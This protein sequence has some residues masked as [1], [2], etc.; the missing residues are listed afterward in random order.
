MRL[1]N[2]TAILTGAGSGLGAYTAKAFA[3]EGAA[4]VVTDIDETLGRQVAQEIEAAGGRAVFAPLDVTDEAAWARVTAAALDSFGKIDILINSAGIVVSKSIEESTL[5]DL[6]KSFALNVEGPFLGIRAVAPAMRRNGGGAIVTIASMSGILGLSR[7]APYSTSKGAV[8]L[9]SK[10]AA[11]HF[12]KKGDNIRVNTVN[13]SYVRTP[14]LESVYSAEQ[15][16]ALESFVPLGRLGSLDDVA[17]AVIYLAS[18]E[19]AF[20][21]GFDLNL[22]GGFTAGN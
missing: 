11:V 1:H 17:D 21:T 12:A 16:Q 3:R 8:R 4:V 15:I 14:M 7:A 2:K 19:S 9:L 20:V 18:D 6:R 5:E 22:D 10:S 13:P